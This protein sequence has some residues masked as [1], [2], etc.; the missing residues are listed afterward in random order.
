MRLARTI[1][2]AALALAA[3]TAETRAQPALVLV[4]ENDALASERDY[5]YTQGFRAS[6][7]FN[8]FFNKSFV[9]APFDLVG[10]LVVTLGAPAGPVRRQFEW[11]VGQSIFTPQDLTL[12][13]PNPADRP[14]AGWL[15]TGGSL[16]VETARV[17]LD[18]F[19]FLGGVVGPSSG[20]KAVQCSFHSA[21][22]QSCP[23]GWSYQLK[24]E[25]AFLA[26]WER[27]WK[28][29]VDYGDGFGA[30][31]IPSVGVTAGN[32]YT[33][34][35]AGALLRWGRSLSS[36]WGPTRVRPAPSGASFFAPDPQGPAWGFSLFAGAEGRA[37]AY[38][39]FLDGNT[40]ASSPSV[41]HQVF[42][43]DLVAGAE[44]FTQY[45]SRLAFTI[46]KRTPEFSSQP[47]NGDL[48]G[49]IEAR[50]QF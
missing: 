48:F 14:Y 39:V 30:D 6:L 25:P 31:I 18:S 8:D 28:L 12:V 7:V 44:I 29:G 37:V 21:L 10:G 32:V 16:A 19:E 43:A 49:S 13:P 42:V 23:L 35:S 20:G 46:T 5:G 4:E 24:D 34:A 17:Q 2:L 15:Y 45:G 41:N 27:R 36:T 9:D 47:G 1:V 26:A 40:F 33:Y 22:G 50:V 3:V 38:N 11:I